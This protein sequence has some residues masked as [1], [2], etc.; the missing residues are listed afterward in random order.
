MTKIKMNEKRYKGYTLKVSLDKSCYRYLTFPGSF[1]LE[2]LAEMILTAFDFN[3]DHLH[4]FFMDGEPYRSGESYYSRYAEEPGIPTNKIKV[5]TLELSEKQKFLFL[6]DFGDDWHFNCEVK[7]IT[8]TPEKEP[9]ISEI[10]GEAPEQYPDCNEFDEEALYE[11]PPVDSYVP[12]ESELYKA[13]FDFKGVKPWRKLTEN[14]VFAV[15]FSDGVVGYAAVTG[16]LGVEYGIT[17]YIGDDGISCLNDIIREPD[18]SEYD[19]VDLFEF[20]LKQDCIIMTLKCKSDIEPEYVSE[21]QSYAKENGISL[22]GKNSFPYFIRYLPQ[23]CLWSVENKKERIY[24]KQALEAATELAKRL[25]SCDK[26]EIRFGEMPIVPLLTKRK[27]GYSWG[28][29][30]L[31]KPSV[32]K[33][34]P[35]SSP[36][37]FKKYK[38]KVELECKIINLP[39]A[40]YN[41]ITGI[42]EYPVI[43]AFVETR[44]GYAMHTDIFPYTS[45]ISVEMLNSFA[46]ELSANKMFPKTI[47]VDDE[48]T[49]ALLSDICDRCGVELVDK[50][51]LPF[52]NGIVKGLV[53]SML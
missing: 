11:R 10:V 44:S 13:A 37:R 5:E 23:R 38:S 16:N 25:E 27:N 49:K 43:T 9:Y 2:D 47:A 50:K 28:S 19:D 39:S 42:P 8:D 35:L 3:N 26:S 1:T 46:D 45:D 52:L 22:R 20:E 18:L 29:A 12:I 30:M 6:F 24:L 34:K 53:G 40:M 15:K 51:A 17:L 32:K 14:D 4:A 31:P 33:Y 41:E 21:I 7:K 36:I 48:R